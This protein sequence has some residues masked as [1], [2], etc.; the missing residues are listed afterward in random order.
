MKKEESHECTKERLLDAAC[1][2]FAEKGYRG[3]SVSQICKA[4]DV[5]V[6]SVSYYFGGKEALYQ[7]AWKHA[8]D[9][10]I[11]LYPPD[12]GVDPSCSP[13]EKLKG[14]IRMG[15]QRALTG[16][17]IELSIIKHEMVNP[18]GLLLQIIEETIEPLRKSTQENLKEI[19]GPNCDQLAM[20]LCE[21]CTVAPWLH[22]TNKKKAKMHKGLSPIFDEKNLT[23]LV[24]YYYIFMLGGIQSIRKLL[25]NTQNEEQS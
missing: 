13:E 22:A 17:G 3:A 23:R 1:K 2:I 20:E 24:E 4:A 15:L 14:R 21:I 8:H 16:D 9:I 19:L 18:T 25:E 6:A 11:K 7:Q 5:N 10:Q 12:G